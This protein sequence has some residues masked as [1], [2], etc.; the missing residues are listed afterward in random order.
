MR[1]A[2]SLRIYVTR[3]VPTSVLFPF[4]KRFISATALTCM[5]K[6]S[7]YTDM[8][9]RGEQPMWLKTP[10]LIGGR[11][12]PYLS[13]DSLWPKQ[14]YYTVAHHQQRLQPTQKSSV[15]G[16]KHCHS[17]FL[18]MF[19]LWYNKAASFEQN[20]QGRIR[21]TNV[22]SLGQ[23]WLFEAHHVTPLTLI[24]LMYEIKNW[25]VFT[26]VK[27]FQCMKFSDF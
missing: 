16:L 19:G 3:R 5:Q 21:V 23:M 1:I 12:C 15:F 27:K 22:Q 17:L 10:R 14:K 7:Q 26:D 2:C 20:I 11:P 18:M 13:W 8:H 4:R 9:C 24:F 25:N 6:H